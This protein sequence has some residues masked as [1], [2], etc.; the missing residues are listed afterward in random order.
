MAYADQN[1]INVTMRWLI[2]CRFRFGS[3]VILVMGI[4][5]SP[6]WAQP[7][8]YITNFQSRTVSVIDTA[9]NTVAATI[10]LGFGPVGAAV[11]PNGKRV[12]VTHGRGDWSSEVTLA[13]NLVSVIDTI[14]NSVVT[15]VTVGDQPV[16]VAITPNAI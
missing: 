12:Y 16:D 4:F 7:F 1:S 5:S 8:A 10:P 6:C 13:P 3:L 15:T 2:A 14:T 11:T 9:T